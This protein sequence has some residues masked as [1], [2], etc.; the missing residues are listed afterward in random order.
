ME[1]EKTFE[2]YKYFRE[3]KFSF[4]YSGEFNNYVLSNATDLVH[5][6]MNKDVE[7]V[8]KRVFYLMVESFQNIVRHSD[9][10][11]VAVNDLFMVRWIDDFFFI[12]TANLVEQAKVNSMKIY[13]DKVNSLDQKQLKDLYIQVLT[14]KKFSENGGAGLGFIDMVR[15]T[16]NKIYYDF[17]KFLR[18]FYIFFFQLQFPLTTNRRCKIGSA[19]AGESKEIY[20]LISEMNALIVQKAV[21]TNKMLINLLTIMKQ[22]YFDD[23]KNFR[24][25]MSV[26]VEMMQDL[27]DY[28]GQKDQ[29]IYLL[30]KE[31]DGK[32]YFVVGSYLDKYYLDRKIRLIEKYRDEEYEDLQDRYFQCYVEDCDD[33]EIKIMRII[34][35][36]NNLEYKIIQIDSNLYFFIQKVDLKI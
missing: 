18:Q 24:R 10:R 26:I 6:I 30:G 33:S 17:D 12:F 29:M 9:S 34:L 20:Y 11:K 36:S 25:V 5:K 35:D 2:I 21:L 32:I 16:K 3:D 13:L 31:D 15:K 28:Q 19:K 8:K 1:L 4:V 14:N 23:Y 22:N 27:R 7:R